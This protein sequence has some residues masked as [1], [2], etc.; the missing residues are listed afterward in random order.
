MTPDELLVVRQRLEAF[1][2]DVFTPL[3]RSDQRA[4]GET[5]LRGL[6]LDGRRKSMQP[7]AD[8][9]GVD[10][11]GLQQFVTTSTWDTEAVRMRLARRAVEVVAPVVW[12][13][14]D[15]G[16]PKDG[17][18]S[19]GVARQY[20]GTLGKVANCQ[21][22][23]SVHAVTDAASCP[24]DWRL[25][26]PTSWDDQAVDEADR[27]EVIARRSRC[28]IPA[29]EHH[30]PKWSMVV[31]MLDELAE[32]NLRP[33]LLAA[34]AG[35]G[36]NSQFRGALDER[37]VDYIMQVKGDALAHTS[38]VQPV[39]RVWSGRGRPPTRTDPRYPK[40][41]V[42]L[43]EH[44]R[45]AGRA[46]TETI[47]WREGSKGTM[48]SQF[49]FL[50]VRPAG[51]RVARDPNGLLP[52]RWLIAQWPDDQAEPVKYWLSSLPA[53]TSH[54]DLIRYGK[55]RWRIEHDY[56]ELKTGLGLDHFEGRSW[57][58]WHRHV[59]L[60]TAAHLFITELRLDPK[61]DAPA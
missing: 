51:H 46:A 44:I 57:I 60:A 33:P 29:D 53:T 52:Q 47:T 19:P 7:M 35:Y 24:L 43:V 25:F 37:S 54:T 55:I 28:G 41:A 20:S 34:D 3:V 56:R 4:K 23:V 38:D 50:R 45:A 16:F 22:G 6:L 14:D 49:I 39:T 10:H 48:S 17:K 8:R 59:T 12:V 32:Q 36:D 2:V 1:A 27:P 26:L 13:V 30:R 61:A 58:G 31:E 18:G 40:T 11:Q 5:Y 9:L 15:T 42:S 21:I